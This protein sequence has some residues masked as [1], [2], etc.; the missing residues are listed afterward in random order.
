MKAYILQRKGDY[1]LLILSLILRFKI[2]NTTN[3]T[4]ITAYVRVYMH[5]DLMLLNCGVGEDS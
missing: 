1:D 5:I 4:G 2:Q 3:N